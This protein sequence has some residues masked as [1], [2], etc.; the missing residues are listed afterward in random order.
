MYKKSYENILIYDV[1]HKTL[2]GSES[3]LIMFDKVDGFIKDY[4]EIKHLILFGHEK[5]DV[6][7][8]RIK[9]LTGLKSGIAYVDSFNY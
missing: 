5:Y 2:I 4:N 3:F 9:Y 1:L 6:I 7:F 8:N